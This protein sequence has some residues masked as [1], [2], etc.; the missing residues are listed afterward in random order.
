MS[1]VMTFLQKTMR[2]G[3]VGVL[4]ALLHYALL[5]FCVDWMGLNVILGS[6]LGFI[7]AVAFNYLMH[8]KWTFDEPAPHQR[9]LRRYLVM[10]GCGFV[11]NASCMYLIEQMWEMH[12]LLAQTLAM[13]A[14]V[15]WNFVL[16]NTWVFRR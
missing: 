3:V 2:F 9:T 13:V 8:H 5:F 6:S 16:A 7:I 1:T 11:I 10:I 15:L 4:T 12:Y 14:V